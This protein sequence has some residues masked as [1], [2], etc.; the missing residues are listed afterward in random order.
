MIQIDGSVH[1]SNGRYT[2]QCQWTAPRELK[3]AQPEPADDR[4]VFRDEYEPGRANS[5]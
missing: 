5:D 4:A 1:S 2:E 3:A